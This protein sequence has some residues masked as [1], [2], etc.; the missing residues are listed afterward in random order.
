M[1]SIG[2]RIKQ[3]REFLG[4]DQTETASAIGIAGPSLSQIESGE[5]KMPRPTTLMKMAEILETNQQWLLHGTG[6]PG[7][8]DMVVSDPAAMAAYEVLK[9]EHKAAIRAMIAAALK[10]M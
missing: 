9:P 4:M 1:S 5:T 7:M 8:R 6:D 3:R 2:Q 10:E